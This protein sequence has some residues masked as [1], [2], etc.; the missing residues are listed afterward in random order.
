[1]FIDIPEENK[2][3]QEL[4]TVVCNPRY[5]G[6]VG[7]CDEETSCSKPDISVIM[8]TITI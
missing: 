3:N 2:K 4:S 6:G 7:R 8:E 1:M 5:C